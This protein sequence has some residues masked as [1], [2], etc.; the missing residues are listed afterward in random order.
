MHH[1]S[2]LMAQVLWISPCLIKIQ[3][4]HAIGGDFTGA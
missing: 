2:N 4:E 1:L 3:H